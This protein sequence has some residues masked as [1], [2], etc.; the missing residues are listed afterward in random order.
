MSLD[1]NQIY[2]QPS[3][4]SASSITGLGYSSCQRR[5]IQ[6]LEGVECFLHHSSS[7]H[8]VCS[9]RQQIPAYQGENNPD[10][11]CCQHNAIRACSRTGPAQK[12]QITGPQ[13][14]K[15]TLGFFWYECSMYSIIH[16]MNNTIPD[17]FLTQHILVSIISNCLTS[18]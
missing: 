5:F 15:L 18:S 8:P 11:S 10:K 13:Q 17:V 4:H 3:D 7:N 6:L 14:S 16:E 12:M 2:F 9:P 1:F